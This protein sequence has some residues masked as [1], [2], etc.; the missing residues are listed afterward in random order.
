MLCLRIEFGSWRAWLT[1]WVRVRVRVLV[2]VR[3][4]VRA[5]VWI[6]ASARVRARARVRGLKVG[7][8]VTTCAAPLSSYRKLCA[9]SKSSARSWCG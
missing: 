4:R 5:V 6:R 8:G 3:P 2:R 1:T 9:R 7:V